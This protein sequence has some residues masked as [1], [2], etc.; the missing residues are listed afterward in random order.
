MWNKLTIPRFQDRQWVLALV[1][2]PMFWVGYAAFFQ[3]A[4]SR[5]AVGDLLPFLSLIFLYP[6][7]EEVVFRGFLQ[8]E[9]LAKDWFRKRILFLS[10]ANLIT[11]VLFVLFHLINYAPVWAIM[12]FFPSLIFGYFRERYHSIAPS[13]LLH[14]YYNAGFALLFNGWSPNV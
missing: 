5:I 2:A 3:P 8:G 4:N 6:I 14:V 7:L 12:V 10:Y 13:I 9:F 11:S 1:V